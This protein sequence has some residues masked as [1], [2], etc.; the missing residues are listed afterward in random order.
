MNPLIGITTDYQASE[1]FRTRLEGVG[2]YLLRETYARVTE[3]AGGIPVLLP[4]M[5]DVSPILD[6]LDG[7]MVTGGNFD[8]PPEISGI[9]DASKA[10][11]IKP[12]RTRYE[13]SLLEGA[14]ERNMPVL[15]ICGGMQLIAIAGGGKLHGDILEEVPESF[16]HEQ[17]LPPT[18]TRH[19]VQVVPGTLLFKLVMREKL[20]V[21]STHHQAVADPG[22]CMVSARAPDG[23]VE[24]VEMPDKYWVL[25]VEWHPELL[26]PHHDGHAAII[27]GFIRA[28]IDRNRS[29]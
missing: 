6:R 24:A 13:M 11:K 26:A 21:N 4:T 9:P 14:L 8:V 10:R 23:I 18:D 19:P 29:E 12:E 17:K 22:V 7:L 5:S 16:D 15:G 25:G 3:T 2:R 28:C 27:R 20:G 1:E